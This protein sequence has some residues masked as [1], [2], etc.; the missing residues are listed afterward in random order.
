MLIRAFGALALV[1]LSASALAIDN[2]Y[3]NQT[4][5]KRGGC[6]GNPKP[7][8]ASIIAYQ[9]LFAEGNENVITE[10][11]T[12]TKTSTRGGNGN[13][14][15]TQRP[16]PAEQSPKQPEPD[17]PK[18]SPKPKPK[19]SPANNDDSS[20]S[21]SGSGV[22]ADERQAWLDAHNAARAQYGAPP[23][24]WDVNAERQAAANADLHKGTCRLVHTPW[25]QLLLG[26]TESDSPQRWPA[27]VRR[28][29]RNGNQSYSQR[30]C[31]HVHVRS[32]YVHPFSRC[33]LRPETLQR[34]TTTTMQASRVSE[35][36]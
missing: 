26:E 19:E 6:K 4:E 13:G 1:T 36:C 8:S 3:S 14:Q 18:P 11:V 31:R 24:A 32:E 29:P 28:E 33:K 23:V 15:N 17:T 16:R 5:I 2:P 9:A 35:K 7:D 12:V 27:Q 21:V 30:G 25:V 22:S 34:T 10:V 20:D